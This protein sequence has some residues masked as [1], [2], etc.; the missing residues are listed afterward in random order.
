[1]TANTKTKQVNTANISK[2]K[3]ISWICLAVVSFTFFLWHVAAAVLT[4]QTSLFDS[5]NTEW[6]QVPENWHFFTNPEHSLMTREEAAT[7]KQQQKVQLSQTKQQTKEQK[8]KKRSSNSLISWQMQAVP[9]TENTYLEYFNKAYRCNVIPNER[10][11]L[12]SHV[13]SKVW[14]KTNI[15]T[16][17]NILVMGDSVAMQIAELLQ[18]AMRI[19]PRYR[20][21]LRDLYPHDPHDAGQHESLFWGVSPR[22]SARKGKGSG[23]GGGSGGWRIVNWWLKKRMNKPLPEAFGGG[24]AQEDVPKLLKSIANLTRATAKEKRNTRRDPKPPRVDVLVFRVSQPWMEW[25]EMTFNK[26]HKTIATAKEQLHV[27]TVVFMTIPFSNNIVDARDVQEMHAKNEMI[28]QFAQNY[29]TDPE[30]ESGITVVYLDL[31]QL[32]NQLVQQNA[33]DLGFSVTHDKDFDFS[34]DILFN[35]KYPDPQRQ[36]QVTHTR[37]IGQ[38]CGGVKVPHNATD[39]VYDNMI[40][41]DGQHLCLKTFGGRLMA[42]MACVIRCATTYVTT[43]SK[44]SSSGNNRGNDTPLLR[45]CEEACNDQYMSL[46]ELED[47]L[48]IYDSET[49]L[50]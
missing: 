1:M 33:L 14:F 7:A 22:V 36:D 47:G 46:R 42:G 38:I 29:P 37:S 16:P 49:S 6:K 19:P 23:G 41:Y 13:K 35:P 40:S 5:E 28:K 24:W 48:L 50:L 18:E 15:T 43:S 9:A 32:N 4:S 20:T 31:A 34:Y 12:P 45:E 8:Q 39:C 17:L 2:S 11:D 26:M 25:E 27:K 44:G 30:R 3:R 21:L 10:V